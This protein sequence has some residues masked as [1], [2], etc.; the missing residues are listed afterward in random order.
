MY[1]SAPKRASFGWSYEQGSHIV[2]ARE[3]ND[4]RMRVTPLQIPNRTAR[5]LWLSAQHLSDAPI[6][7][8]DASALIASLGFVQLDSIQNIARAHHH[9]IWSRMQS[10][11]EPMMARMMRP[12]RQVF[13]HFT[14]DASVLPMDM[15]PMWQ[16]QF[17]R[18]KDKIERSGWYST[19]LDAN[20]RDKIKDRIARD[21]PLS[22][23]A[24]NSEHARKGEMW[25]RPPHKLALDYMWYTGELATCHRDGFTKVY[26]LAENV[27]PAHLR[28][29]TMPDPDQVRWLCEGAM[30]R[31]SFGTT[32][33]IQRFWDA[34]TAVEAR[35]WVAQN[36]ALVPVQY[37]TADGLWLDAVAA[38]DIEARI[39]AL[40]APSSRLRLL[41]PFDPVIR[42]RTR[43]T[44]LFGFDYRNE[45]FVPAA[46]RIWGYY[47]YPLLE[48]DRF[49]GRV[50]AKADR[51]TGTLNVL[52]QWAEP[53]VKWSAQRQ[54]KLDAEL[55]RFARF[56]GLTS[57]VRKTR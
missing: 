31:I 6:G 26:D 35:A 54:K 13:E 23:N 51:K 8:S 20:E 11:R 3:P 22:T 15:L 56:A 14:H 53:G 47:V 25:A 57:V 40:T 46:K 2:T 18:H 37:Q 33:D 4:W 42:D 10:Y 55:D 52:N 34:I 48:G 27:F 32:G 12:N 5:R 28:A 1:R 39:A 19:M 16:R 45:I 24:F 36:S 7:V 43:L 29:Q 41:N 9:I 17:T 44:R 38:S 49:V 21:G 30:D 50:E